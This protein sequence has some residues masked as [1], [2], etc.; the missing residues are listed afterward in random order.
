MR[1]RR[2][3]YNRS[4]RRLSRLRDYLAAAVFLA[5]IAVIAAFLGARNEE[6]ASDRAVIADGDTIEINGSR[7]RLEGIDSPEFGQLCDLAGREVDCG[8][9]ARNHL[10]NLVDQSPVTCNGWLYDKY[11]R[12]LAT[13]IAN[14]IELNQRMVED[15]WA[16]SYGGYEAEELSARE[17]NRGLWQGDFMRPSDWRREQGTLTADETEHGGHLFD[18]M[19]KGVSNWFSG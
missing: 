18:R 3:K 12:L 10:R 4:A 8:R 15:G 11:D 9:M 14:G 1:K 19:F 16:V 6:Q 2:G 7:I 13:C 5:V 17:N